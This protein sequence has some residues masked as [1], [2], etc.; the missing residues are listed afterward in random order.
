M[1]NISLDALLEEYG[2]REGLTIRGDVIEEWPYAEPMPSAE[3]CAE[4]TT[5]YL[6]ANEYKLK[7]RREYPS[8]REKIE[9]LAN[10]VA[11]GTTTLKD[12][13]AEIDAKYPPP[14]R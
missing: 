14:E 4:L 6:A 9:M 2:H 3:R 11:N 12:R 5:N 10:D 13:M 7:R 1:A 8:D